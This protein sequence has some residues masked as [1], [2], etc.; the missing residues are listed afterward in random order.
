MKTKK[1]EVDNKTIQ[2]ILEYVEQVEVKIDGEWGSCRTFKELLAEYEY[3][4]AFYKELKELL[5]KDSSSLD[6]LESRVCGNCEHCG[7]VN[8]NRLWC[9]VEVGS[10]EGRIV[11][12]DFGCN[13]FERC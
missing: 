9:G 13:K 12:K 1:I 10:F 8:D 2:A 4:P 11:T 5:V 3:V 7:L 6:D